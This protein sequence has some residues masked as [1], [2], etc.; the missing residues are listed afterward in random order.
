MT[1]L[2]VFFIAL[3]CLA[4]IDFLW[5]GIIANSMY[6]TGLADLARIEDGK[7][8]PVMWA[9]VLVYLVLALGLALFV[10]PQI[11]ADDSWLKALGYGAMLGFVVY[12]VYDMTNLSTLAKWPVYLS[13][14]DWIWG[15][16][17]CGSVSLITRL[18][19]D[20]VS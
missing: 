2:K 5:I 11:S 18:L 8:K 12:G 17:L 9:A 20:L 14:I 3:V 7:I 15:C 13:L 4:V 10:L 19:R 1:H 16:V 6:M